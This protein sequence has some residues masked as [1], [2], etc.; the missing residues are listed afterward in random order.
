M[1]YEVEREPGQWHIRE[2]GQVTRG[3]T[4]TDGWL[5]QMG[6][7]A[8]SRSNVDEVVRATM[9]VGSGQVLDSYA[10]SRMPRDIAFRAGFKS[11]PSKG[12]GMLPRNPVRSTR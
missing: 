4:V 2:R 11:Y 7:G 5:R 1:E 9:A 12:R 10:A 8:L 6:F 3:T